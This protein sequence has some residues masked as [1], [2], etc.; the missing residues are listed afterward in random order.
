[1]LAVSS[2]CVSTRKNAEECPIVSH[3]IITL[4]AGRYR[5]QIEHFEYHWGLQKGELDL[6]SPHNHIEL[7]SDM[8]ERLRD[9]EW[10]LV[11]TSETLQLMLEVSKYNM[12]ASLESRKHCLNEFPD[13][14]HE[15]DIVPLFLLQNGRPALYVNEGKST[16]TFRAPYKALPRI[17]SRAHPFFVVW[18]ASEQ[19]VGTAPILFSEKKSTSLTAPVGRVVHCWTQEPPQA[20]LIGP[21]VWKEHRHPLSDDGY[22]ARFALRDSRKG[23]AAKE[24]RVRKTTR[25]PCRQAKSTTVI[26]PYARCDSRPARTRGS[27]LPRSGVDSGDEGGKGYDVAE[28][29]AWVD[30]IVPQTIA[31]ASNCWDPAWL[32]HELGT[33]EDLARYRREAARDVAEALDPQMYADTCGTLTY[34]SVDRSRVCSN[35]WARSAYDVCL[36][37]D[38]PYAR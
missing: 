17:K 23:N 7:R 35:V 18:M 3:R 13:A 36:W 24:S 33:D 28:L 4:D 12:T 37:A 27:A 16:K 6:D 30:S 19:L 8:D 14:E 26:T 21:D 31:E 32:D 5:R 15:Y 25:A 29:R 20:F 2:D 9:L 11:P 1:M 22:V 10:T 38:D 34:K